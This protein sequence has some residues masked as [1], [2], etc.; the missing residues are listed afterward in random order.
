MNAIDLILLRL[1][2]KQRARVPQCHACRRTVI[3]LCSSSL[4]CVQWCLI[5]TMRISCETYRSRADKVHCRF[6]AFVSQPNGLQL[7]NTKRTQYLIIF[8]SSV[9]RSNLK[10]VLKQTSKSTFDSRSKPNSRHVSVK[11]VRNLRSTPILY[12]L[13]NIRVFYVGPRVGPPYALSC[14][15][16]R[17]CAP[18]VYCV[19]MNQ[20]YLTVST[21]LVRACA[22]D[23]HLRHDIII[24]MCTYTKVFDSDFKSKASHS[25]II[26]FG[27][28]QSVISF[29]SVKFRT[30][31]RLQQLFRDDFT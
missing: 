9:F 11:V 6:C 25:H 29:Q 24:I 15:L 26:H 22:L 5:I 13:F 12:T 27:R 20:C 7:L 4:L 16:F 30:P 18:P 19:V 17:E 21:L 2:R 1:S 14:T 8:Y 31:R 23:A 3:I 28:V 10:L